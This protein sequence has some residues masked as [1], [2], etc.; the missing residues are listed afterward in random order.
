M[1]KYLK[2]F[3][4]L[5]EYQDFINS[6]EYIEPNVTLITG[7]KSLYYNNKL[8]SSD[9]MGEIESF[10]MEY[11]SFEL[12]DNSMISFGNTENTIQYS[13]DKEQWDELA[14]DERISVTAGKTIYFKA[15]NPS[16]GE[17]YG[18]G[19][20]SSTGRFNVKGNIMS[21]LY[22]DN[23][24]NQVDLTGKK[25]CF[26]RLFTS[27]TTLVDASKM[28]LPATSLSEYA[29]YGLF[30]F[31]TS[32]TSAPKLPATA[33][34]TGCYYMM[35]QG[36]TSLVNAPELPATT[37]ASSCYT[38]MFQGCTNLKSTPALPATTLSSYCYYLMFH[39]CSNLNNITML[40]T[41]IS[42]TDCLRE[43]VRDVAPTGTFYRN[44]EMTSLPIGID[45]IPEGWKVEGI[46]GN[47]ILL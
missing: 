36:C 12:I 2:L 20:F 35:F 18:I 31:C 28:V 33:L 17:E 16:I 9:G 7:S 38:G 6:S 5:S 32:L 27:C 14:V 4:K 15:S 42:A 34:T 25:A 43:W 39:S 23:F 44:P 13:L 22:G 1:G 29:Y 47:D 8:S 21:M 37:L 46:T 24:D 30:Q 3:S 10:I 40:A 26:N 19:T 11:L 41:D 45:G